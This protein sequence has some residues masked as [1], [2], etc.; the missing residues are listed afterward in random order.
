MTNHVLLS[1]LLLAAVLISEAAGEATSSFVVYRNVMDYGAKGNGIA[2][3]TD[4]FVLALT[5]DKATDPQP[6]VWNNSQYNCQTTKPSLVYVPSGVYRITATLPL[7]YYSQ[8]VGEY[9]SRPRLV[10]SGAYFTALDA[11]IDE[12]QGNGWYGGVNQNNFYHQVRN[13]VVDLT[14]CTYCVALHWQ[15][16]QA[17]N[18]VNVLFL[19][20]DRSEMNTGVV[21]ENGSGGY[22]GDMEFVGGDVAMNLGNQQFTVRNVSINGSTTGISL[23]WNWIWAFHDVCITNV[24]KAIVLGGGVSSVSIIDAEISNAFIGVQ[25]LSN[26]TQVTLDGAVFSNVDQPLF[27][28]GTSIGNN[29]TTTLSYAFERMLNGSFVKGEVKFPLRPPLL[30]DPSTGK[31]FGMTRPNYLSFISATLINDTDVTKDLQL[32]LDD[33]VAKGE[34]L[35]V[36]YGVYWISSTVHIPL[37]TRLFGQAWTRFAPQGPYFSNAASPKAMFQVG[38]PGDVGVAQ[39]AD[40]M[41]TTRGPCPGA[42]MLEW[43]VSGEHPGDSGLWDVHHRIGGAAGSQVDNTNCPK[44]AT[45][46]TSPQCV[47]AHSLFHIKPN[48]SVYVENMWGWVGDHNIDSGH[49]V[50]CFNAR[51]LVIE[52]N[53]AV[54]LYGTAMEHSFLYQYNL[55][56]G[57]ANVLL[58]ILQTETPYFQPQFKLLGSAPSDPKFFAYQYH[59]FSIAASF[60]PSNVV[61]FG[62]GMYS[63]FHQWNQ[64]C[65][66]SGQPDCQDH[67]SAWDFTAADDSRSVRLHNFNTHGATYVMSF[68]GIHVSAA[69]TGNGFC[70][71]TSH[72][73][74]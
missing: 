12:G 34:P 65:G 51:G 5:Q 52:T 31:F 39:I 40:I 16:S 71:T 68:D 17:T 45:M 15:V 32:A 42:I 74:G 50:N 48:A 36:P 55:G 37:G 54:W 33:A 58:S 28:N 26:T 24:E 19:L 22:F 29:S 18:I 67:M 66:G 72:W 30:L 64:T 1:L 2:D 21:M 69:A 7:T 46:A 57:A 3:D 60:S 43:H 11:G 63:F 62:T 56:P 59:S 44:N 73:T 8:L 23:N 49:G 4:A 20:G 10:V 41:L 53:R 27:V 6:G 38:N 14:Q 47:G 61:L 9:H 25:T 35:L 13:I 70:S